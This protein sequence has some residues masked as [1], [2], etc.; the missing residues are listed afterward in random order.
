MADDC[1]LLKKSAKVKTSFKVRNTTKIEED[2]KERAPN[3]FV[4]V[5]VKMFIER[6]HDGDNLWCSYTDES[7]TNV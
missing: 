3:G 7:M 2:L 4:Q 1:C 6:Y 5:P